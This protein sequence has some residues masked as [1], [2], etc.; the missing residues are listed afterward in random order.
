MYF[1]HNA[2]QIGLALF[3]VA[4]EKTYLARLL[5]AGNIIALLEQ[6]ATLGIDDD[7]ACDL[8]AL[9]CAHGLQYSIGRARV[10]PRRVR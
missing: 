8:V 3:A 2:L 9:W 6:K 7:G 1:P 10:S 5:N 4:A